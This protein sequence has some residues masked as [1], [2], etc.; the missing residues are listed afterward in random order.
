MFTSFEIDDELF[1]Q[2]WGLSGIAKKK[3]F[4]AETLRTYVRLHEQAAVRSLR[5]KLVWKGDLDEIR[6]ERGAGSR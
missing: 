2:A 6:G 5:G 4:I 3:D 1:D